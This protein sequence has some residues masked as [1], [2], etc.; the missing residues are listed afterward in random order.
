MT[1]KKHKPSSTS[2]TASAATI[3]P[4]P[5]SAPAPA[6]DRVVHAE[7]MSASLGEV[8]AAEHVEEAIELLYVKDTLPEG[9]PPA[10]EV[11][12][13]VQVAAAAKEGTEVAEDVAAHA[14]VHDA[15]PVT[16]TLGG[17]GGATST[18]APTSLPLW[19]RLSPFRVARAAKTAATE[20]RAGVDRA[21]ADLKDGA[22]RA[23][24][25]LVL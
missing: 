13:D 20:L 10:P 24:Q 21:V 23:R 15:V 6:T 1:K 19:K 18:S 9:T 11:A 14:E 4:A 8:L 3:A 16:A 17:A 22:Q 25:A 12:A 2:K 5:A 7:E